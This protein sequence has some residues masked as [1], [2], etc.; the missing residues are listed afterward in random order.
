MVAAWEAQEAS[1]T[2]READWLEARQGFEEK[3]LTLLPGVEII[4][5]HA[6]RLW[7]TVLLTVPAPGNVKWLTRL[8]ALGFAVST[9]SACSRGAGASDV[10]RAMGLPES[11]QGQVL[12]LSAGWDTT[13]DHW[14]ALAD[15]LATVSATLGERP[16]GPAPAFR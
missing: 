3:I 10:L 14:L 6:Q 11:N 4:A 13:P 7:N 9:G 16:A 5:L 8:S 15:A 2:A 1:L 12:R